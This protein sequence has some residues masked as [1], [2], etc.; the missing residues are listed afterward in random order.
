[1]SYSMPYSLARPASGIKRQSP[2]AGDLIEPVTP[3]VG[4]Q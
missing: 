2:E 3:G 1:M 4:K